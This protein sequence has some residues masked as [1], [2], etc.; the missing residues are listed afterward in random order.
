VRDAHQLHR[1]KLQLVLQ[2]CPHAAGEEL[3][4]LLQEPQ[5]EAL[6]CRRHDGT[7]GKRGDRTLR[8]V[9]VRCLGSADCASRM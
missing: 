6:C 9:S 7:H 5:K 8:T 1:I 3:L 4:R 2:G